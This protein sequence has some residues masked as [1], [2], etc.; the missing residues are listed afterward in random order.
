[1]EE[2]FD[3]ADADMEDEGAAYVDDSDLGPVVSSSAAAPAV[4][5]ASPKATAASAETAANSP[6]AAL[7]KSPLSSG[8]LASCEHHPA[9]QAWLLALFVGARALCPLQLP[10]V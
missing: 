6:A 1:M 3:P 4:A 9:P 7:A 8:I 10:K 2:D 5:A